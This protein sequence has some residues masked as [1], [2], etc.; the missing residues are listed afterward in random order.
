MFS[1]NKTLILNGDLVL[2]YCNLINWTLDRDSFE[3]DF[4]Y[5]NLDNIDTWECGLKINKLSYSY[6]IDL[7]GN[8]ESMFKN[9]NHVRDWFF[10]YEILN[11]ETESLK[12]I[13]F[14]FSNEEIELAPIFKRVI[15]DEKFLYQLY[16]FIKNIFD[17]E[18]EFII[19]R[20]FNLKTFFKDEEDFNSLISVMKL[21]A[22]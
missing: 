10:D 15:E 4:E 11:G 19:S 20:F 5:F 22:N 1:L 9:R 18:D 8:I 14:I 21:T 17:N 12:R 3:G 7:T 2:K 6:E 13:A 16:E